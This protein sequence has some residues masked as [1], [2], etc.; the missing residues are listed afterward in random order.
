MFLTNTI[1]KNTIDILPEF[2]SRFDFVVIDDQLKKIL[3]D[4]MA[5]LT[6]RQGSLVYQLDKGT[7]LFDYLWENISSDLLERIQLEMKY[8]LET[9]LNIKI[10]ELKVERDQKDVHQINIYISIIL[11]E[12]A[13]FKIVL[14]LQKQGIITVEEASK[15]I[16]KVIIQ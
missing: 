1:K 4:I 12:D 11:S 7:K 16:S 14:A 2:N 3:R 6:L 9:S 10:K 8:S 13:D 15:V 5:I